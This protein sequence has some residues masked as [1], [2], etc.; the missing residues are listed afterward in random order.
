MF[1]GLFL[2]GWPAWIVFHNPVRLNAK[3]QRRKKTRIEFCA[4]RALATW[5][6]LPFPTVPKKPVA[7]SACPPTAYDTK[8]LV[9]KNCSPQLSAGMLHCPPC[10]VN[11]RPL[12][13]DNLVKAVSRQLKNGRGLRADF[14]EGLRA[15]SSAAQT[16]SRCA[17]GP[18]MIA[19]HGP[20]TYHDSCPAL[21]R[22]RVNTSSPRGL[23][24]LPVAQ[25]PLPNPP[26]SH[27]LLPALNA[28]SAR[29]SP[30]QEIKK[31]RRRTKPLRGMGILPRRK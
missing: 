13:F 8:P 23:T 5:R 27:D 19:T 24:P 14:P 31:I 22:P 26:S 10:A 25:R 11:M 20:R 28:R 17:Q 15:G 30:H 2:R 7:A 6:L 3:T 18:T 16:R 12:L 21:P 1:V 9:A 4:L 29:I